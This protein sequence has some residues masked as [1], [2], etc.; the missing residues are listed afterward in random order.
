MNRALIGEN[1]AV[2]NPVSLQTI[3]VEPLSRASSKQICPI[4]LFLGTWQTTR[5]ID[6]FKNKERRQ[7]RRSR[8]LRVNHEAA[9]VQ[10]STALAE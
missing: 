5:T 2:Q 9:I 8:T 10:S 4:V 1:V 6:I 7:N 3:E